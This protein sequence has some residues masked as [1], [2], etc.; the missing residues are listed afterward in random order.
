MKAKKRATKKTSK[1]KT[2]KKSKRKLNAWQL[3]VKKTMKANPGMKFVEVLK[4]AKK[5][6]K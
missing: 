1:A 2:A 5:T 4:K 3:H 6:Y